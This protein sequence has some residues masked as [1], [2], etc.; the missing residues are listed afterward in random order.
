MRRTTAILIII[1]LCLG[2]TTAIGDC[3]SKGTAATCA[4]DKSVIL[5]D[6]SGSKAS[7]EMYKMIVCDTILGYNSGYVTGER[8]VCYFDPTECGDATY[9]FEITSFAFSLLDPA[10]IYDPRI[11]KWP[12]ELDVIVYEPYSLAD[13]CLGPGTEICRVPV[14]CDSTTF[15]YPHCGTVTFPT[16]CCAESAFFIGIEYTDTYTGALPSILF[17]YSS[18]PDLCHLYQFICGTTWIGWY[19][20]W[21]TPPGYPFFWVNGETMS[22]NCCDDSDADGVCDQ[23]DICPGYDDNADADGDGVPDGCDLCAG[24]DDALDDDADG[25]PDGC[26]I[27]PGYDD[28]LDDDADGVPDGCDNCR[29]D[30]NA[31]QED[32]DTD[33]AG[34][35]CDNCPGVFNPS[36]SDL[37]DDGE[38]NACDDDDDGDGEPDVSDNCPLVF[39]P[40]QEDSDTDGIGD[41]CECVGRV[42]NVDCDP[43]DAV[44]GSDLSWL[45]DHLFINLD[46]VCSFDEANV[47]LVGVVIDGADLSLLIDHLFIHPGNPLP[48]CPRR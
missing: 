40:G 19:A 27:C 39:N 37:D 41:A 6:V 29:Y 42:G 1:L 5:P 43:T 23:Y 32:G 17:D 9:P 26:D 46:P 4:A 21:V 36:Q 16:P 15:A 8:T 25:V 30:A 44:D 2:G 45:I 18:E 35:V 3:K 34:D 24:H 10:Q 13:T 47:D 12:V 38:G 14:L 33:G 31:G 7:C 20:Y 11:Y 22:T 28:T 48:F